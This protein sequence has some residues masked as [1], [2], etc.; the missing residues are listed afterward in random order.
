MPNLDGSGPTGKGPMTGRK[1]G[2]CPDCQGQ[3][4]GMARCKGCG[5]GVRRFWMSH[6]NDVNDLKAI[7]E[8]LL[9][10][11]DD[12]RKEITKIEDQKK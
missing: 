5:L 2:N 7:E 4:K 12:L 3:Y 9:M 8:Q 10:D 6:D 1:Q 11:L